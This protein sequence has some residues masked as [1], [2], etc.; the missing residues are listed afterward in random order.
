[1][2][3]ID[4]VLASTSSSNGHIRSSHATPRAGSS[5]LTLREAISRATK[6]RALTKTEIL[7][8]VQKIGYKFSSADPMGSINAFLYGKAGKREFRNDAGKFSC[9]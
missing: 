4:T 9:R 5:K 7:E 1:M 3:Q 2:E 6:T 8:A